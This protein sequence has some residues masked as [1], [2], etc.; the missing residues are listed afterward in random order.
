MKVLIYAESMDARRGGLETAVSQLAGK[1]AESGHEVHAA[2]AGLGRGLE[3]VQY[4]ALSRGERARVRELEELRAALQ[5]DITHAVLPCLGADIYQPHGGLIPEIVE[6]NEAMARGRLAKLWRGATL[7]LNAKRRYRARLEGRLLG[8]GAR[9][10]VAAVS[11]YVARQC[12]RHYGLGGQRVR[13]VFNGVALKGTDP[14]WRASQRQALRQRWGVPSEAALA[15]FVAHQ[16]RLKGLDALIQAVARGQAEFRRPEGG[17]RVLIVG[18]GKQ[19]AYQRRIDRLG[20][21]DLMRFCGPV[22]QMA[23]VFAA[24]D[25]LVLPTYYDPCSLVSLEAMAAGLPVITTRYNGAAELITH[26]VNGYVLEEPTDV[27]GLC[28]AM[29]HLSD[30]AARRAAAASLPAGEPLS[31]ERHVRQM[32]ELYG[33]VARRRGQKGSGA[34]G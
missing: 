5:P 22:A 11:G 16:F 24:S 20:V 15:L 23:A 14:R 28:E 26:G 33:Q 18:R 4:H 19:R 25:W 21:G 30:P 8:P 1:L 7:R 17:L 31:L 34:C 27:G 2:A 10:V 29:L 32:V 6:R 12:Q 3:G 9:T 13:V